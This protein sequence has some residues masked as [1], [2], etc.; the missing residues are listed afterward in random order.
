MC[1]RAA[2]VASRADPTRA[3]REY[4]RTRAQL[5]PGWLA[6]RARRYTPGMGALRTGPPCDATLAASK[7]AS[8]PTNV[9]VASATPAEPRL[10]PR[11]PELPSSRAPCD[12]PLAAHALNI[13]GAAD[14]RDP[15][16]RGG[17]ATQY[18]RNVIVVYSRL[19]AE[20]TPGCGW[21]TRT[22]TGSRPAGCES[23]A[24]T[25]SAT[26]APCSGTWWSRLLRR[27]FTTCHAAGRVN[28][29]DH[30]RAWRC[31]PT[32]ARDDQRERSDV[33]LANAPLA[34]PTVLVALD[35]GP[36]TL[37]HFL[38]THDLTARS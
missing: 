31:I 8:L 18:A 23:A 3:P 2:T 13:K 28:L 30:L 6:I 7:L 37:D 32:R 25:S 38:T 17:E 36:P 24:S 5:R 26:P 21:E 27:E 33:C 1:P 4:A 35:P 12:V 10:Q 29:R 22:P 20:S 34:T 16:V 14:I 9:S 15:F 19:L 11:A